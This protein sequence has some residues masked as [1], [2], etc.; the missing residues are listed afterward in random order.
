MTNS[1]KSL[2]S[3]SVAAK[4]GHGLDS[5]LCDLGLGFRRN[6][7]TVQQTLQLGVELADIGLGMATALVIWTA[8]AAEG[9][10]E[11]WHE[12]KVDCF[13]RMNCVKQR[14]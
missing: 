8:I 5:A 4:N 10:R 11:L 6:I 12:V 13:A 3:D 2:G 1:L 7:G 14:S 9:E